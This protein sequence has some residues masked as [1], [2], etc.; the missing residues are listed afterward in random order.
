MMVV[1]HLTTIIMFK[2]ARRKAP[3]AVFLAVNANAAVGVPLCLLLLRV[4]RL[5][6]IP[7]C[8][9]ASEGTRC[10]LSERVLSVEG[11]EENLPVVLCCNVPN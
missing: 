11:L 10:M 8:V 9:G 1:D 5:H 3:I 2:V 4:A 6:R 7:E